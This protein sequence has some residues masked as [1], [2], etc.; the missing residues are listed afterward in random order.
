MLNC[1][2]ARQK[3]LKEEDIAVCE[4]KYDPSNPESGCGESC[5]NVL[6]NTECTPGYCPS[7]Q[8][9]RNQVRKHRSVSKDYNY[10][11]RGSK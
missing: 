7:G 2:L 8:H 3:K 9:C 10:E 11:V 1:F 6:T 4:C 5:L